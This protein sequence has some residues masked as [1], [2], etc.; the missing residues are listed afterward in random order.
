ML[1]DATGMRRLLPGQWTVK[2]A[3]PGPPGPPE[4][5]EPPP[6]PDSGSAS[7]RM[8][9]CNIAGEQWDKRLTSQASWKWRAGENR[10][11]PAKGV[12]LNES[13]YTTFTRL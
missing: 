11:R 6:Q 13:V 4:L 3:S 12:L 5:P 2:D 1:S 8:N 9:I 10:S 7:K